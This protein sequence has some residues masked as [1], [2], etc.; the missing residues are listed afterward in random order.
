[1]VSDQYMCIQAN[2]GVNPMF[3]NMT[4]HSDAESYG[5]QDTFVRINE[6]IDIDDG[7]LMLFEDLGFSAGDYDL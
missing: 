5:I 2:N 4:V 7:L 6:S 1:M 3:Y